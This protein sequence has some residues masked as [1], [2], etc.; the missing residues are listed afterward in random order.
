MNALSSGKTQKRNMIDSRVRSEEQK[1]HRHLQ[2]DHRS[3]GTDFG[4]MEKVP[5]SK[6]VNQE[7]MGDRQKRS[8]GMG[9]LP[10]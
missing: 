10:R 7:C 9:V 8:S 4:K 2:T 1:N 6:L 5:A 3:V